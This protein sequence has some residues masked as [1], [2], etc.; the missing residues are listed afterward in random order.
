M[1]DTKH[2]ALRE[3]TDLLQSVGFG[4]FSFQHLAD[5]LGIKKPSLYEH[6]ESK[7]ALGQ[8][9]VEEYHRS[10]AA[11]TETISVFPPREQVGALF[12]LVFGYSCDDR[13]VCPLLAL[14]GGYNALPESMKKLVGRLFDFQRAWLEGILAQG[15]K[16][17][18]IRSDM[19]PSQLAELVHATALGAQPMARAAEDPNYIRR[20]KA[21][22]LGLLDA[23]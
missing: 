18:E 10:F 22:V 19:P 8:A 11:W 20:L 6:F 5:R 4:G 12:E 21:R 14:V 23:P 15:Q 2:L 7:E 9:L 3:A 16:A 13:K 1:R 17:G